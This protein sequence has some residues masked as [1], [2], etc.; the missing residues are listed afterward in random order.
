MRPFIPLRIDGKTYQTIDYFPK[1]LFE[2]KTQE[3]DTIKYEQEVITN[4]IHELN[5]LEQTIND[6]IDQ[7]IVADVHEQRIQRKYQKSLQR[8]IIK[9]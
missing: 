5:D 6:R 3:I 7:K 8:H 9:D 1:L 4:H 2:A